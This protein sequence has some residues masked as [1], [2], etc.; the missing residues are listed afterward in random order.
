MVRGGEARM[1]KYAVFVGY[2]VRNDTMAGAMI[3][4]AVR[5]RVA[6]GE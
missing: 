5:E 1:T 3:I 2:F 4:R 6:S